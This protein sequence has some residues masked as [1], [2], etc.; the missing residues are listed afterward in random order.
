M[1]DALA[2][3]LKDE[4]AKAE[5]RQAAAKKKKKKKTAPVTWLALLVFTVLSGYVWLGSPSWLESGPPPVPPTLSDA[6]LRLE[7]FRQA[8]LVEE[9][10]EAQG[11]LPQD[12]AEAGDPFSEVDYERLDDGTYRLA[13]SGPFGSVEYSSGDSLDAFL[14][15]ALQVI[16]QGG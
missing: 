11:R 13:F 12:L 16:R 1:A 14:G 4:T 15:N 3:V 6:G 10:K 5:T 9:F 2:E 7:V 8:L